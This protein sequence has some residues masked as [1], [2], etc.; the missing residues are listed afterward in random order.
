MNVNVIII[1]YSTYEYLLN[2]NVIITTYSTYEY[3]MN[4]NVII[5]TFI[6]IYGVGKNWV[7]LSPAI[8]KR[9]ESEIKKLRAN[10]C[11]RIYPP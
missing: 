5:T 10:S 6:P 4:V 9:C 7:R 11:S 2:V 3:L 1:T 8:N